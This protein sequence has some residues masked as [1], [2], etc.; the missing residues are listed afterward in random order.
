MSKL[1]QIELTQYKIKL[2]Y[3]TL[4]EVKKYLNNSPY[5]D[6]FYRTFDLVNINKKQIVMHFNGMYSFLLAFMKSTNPITVRPT[7]LDRHL[8]DIMFFIRKKYFAHYLKEFFKSDSQA[9]IFLNTYT[10]KYHHQTT[11]SYLMIGDTW[12]YEELVRSIANCHRPETELYNRLT[13]GG[14][15]GSIT[16]LTRIKEIEQ[17][18]HLFVPFAEV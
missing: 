18:L 15:L 10:Q 14:R 2:F 13:I 3:A 8:A 1:S 5:R 12:R 6:M 7:V 4:R 17:H 9:K 11:E 16:E